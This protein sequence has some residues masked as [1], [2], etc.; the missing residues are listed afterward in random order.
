VTAS[1]ERG[2]SLAR[3]PWSRRE[4]VPPL[5]VTGSPMSLSSALWWPLTFR[6]KTNYWS[7]PN[8]VHACLTQNTWLLNCISPMS[9]C[10]LTHA[11]QS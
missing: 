10:P 6:E 9:R 8:R 11:S 1:V 4:S 7:G 3:A 2:A 5:A